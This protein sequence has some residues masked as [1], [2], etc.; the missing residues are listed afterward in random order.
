LVLDPKVVFAVDGLVMLAIY[1]DEIEC[2]GHD[3]GA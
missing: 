1:L 2:I 3:V